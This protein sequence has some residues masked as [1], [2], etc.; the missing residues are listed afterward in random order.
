MAFLEIIVCLTSKADDLP[1]LGLLLIT[2]FLKRPPSFRPRL[3]PYSRWST[4]S[5]CCPSSIKINFLTWL[6]C[7]ES[8]ESLSI[9][10][11]PL[12]FVRRIQLF[13][14]DYPP[15]FKN[16]GFSGLRSDE[17]ITSWSPCREIFRFCNNFLIVEI[18]EF[19]K[20][21]L[22]FLMFHLLLNV[23]VRLNQVIDVDVFDRIDLWAHIQ[24]D[25]AINKARVIRVRNRIRNS[26][27]IKELTFVFR[28]AQTFWRR[29]IIYQIH[30]QNSI[31]WIPAKIQVWIISKVS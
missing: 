14:L 13:L 20:S 10:I 4:R 12:K 18:L 22:R 24:I 2:D 29:V 26:F 23:V 9:T 28:F 3:L 25:T 6:L 11:Y 21:L 31:L 7:A 27:L 17:E 30:L 1:K 19:L 5:Y 15:L 8:R 16:R